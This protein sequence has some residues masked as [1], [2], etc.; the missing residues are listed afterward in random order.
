MHSARRL[1]AP[2]LLV[3]GLRA[4]VWGLRALESGQQ[5]QGLRALGREQ[6]LPG[7][8][9]LVRLARS[10]VEAALLAWS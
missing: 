5:E 7:A 4:L 2:V 8:G 10:S 6:R 3:W 1:Q 9:G